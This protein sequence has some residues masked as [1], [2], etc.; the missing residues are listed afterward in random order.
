MAD[1]ELCGDDGPFNKHRTFNSEEGAWLCD[2][3]YNKL[4]EII[5][6]SHQLVVDACPTCHHRHGVKVVEYTKDD[7]GVEIC[8]WC[9]KWF[10]Y[11]KELEGHNFC[12]EC[13][14]E[15][16]E[17]IDKALYTVMGAPKDIQCPGCGRNIQARCVVL[18]SGFVEERVECWFCGHASAETIDK[19]KLRNLELPKGQKV[20]V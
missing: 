1:C 9:R 11:T 3:C 13:L 14:R 15:H 10:R 16:R 20:L 19:T 5:G 4:E 12:H 17:E 7:E 8:E 18:P 6:Y 2:D